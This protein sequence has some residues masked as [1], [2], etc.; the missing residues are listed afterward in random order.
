MFAVALVSTLVGSI[1][2][3]T[4]CFAAIGISASH[5]PTA[6]P[7]QLRAGEWGYDIPGK[8]GFDPN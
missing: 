1:I 2:S 6:S 3:A 4:D 8:S 5:S 7:S